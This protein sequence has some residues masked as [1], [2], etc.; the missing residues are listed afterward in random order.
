MHLAII[1][2]R[3]VPC[4]YGGFETFAQKLSISLVERGHKVSVYCSSLYSDSYQRY[5]K[6]VRRIVIPSIRKKSLDKPLYSFLSCLHASLSSYDAVLLLGVSGVV[7]SMLLRITGK[8]TV[9]NMDGLEWKRKK[10][11]PLGSSYLRFLEALSARFCNVIVADSRVIQAYFEKRYG[12]KPYYIPY[13]ADTKDAID[14]D[15]LKQYGLSSGEY[16]LQVCRLEPENNVH[17][18]I[19]EFEKTKTKK[20]LAI[21]GDAPYS[22]QYISSLKN[23]DDPRIKFLGA[24]YEEDYKVIQG[25]AYAYIHGHEVGGT[26]PALLEA[27]AAG[28]CAVVLDAPYNLEVIRGAGFSFSKDEGNLSEVIDYLDQNPQV[29]IEYKGRALQRIAQAY[30]WD[31]VINAY[32]GVF[33]EGLMNKSEGSTYRK[34]GVLPLQVGAV[35]IALAFCYWFTLA[36]LVQTWRENEDYSYGFL[37]PLISAYFLYRQRKSISRIPI[38]T[39]WP[40]FAGVLI[41]TLMVLFGEIGAQA[42]TA[43][44][45]LIVMVSALTLLLFGLEVFKKVAFPVW[46]LFFMLPLPNIIEH[47]LLLPLKLWSSKLSVHLIRFFGISVHQEGNVIDLGFSQLQVVD[48]CSGLRYI[49]PLIALGVVFSYL[50]QGER[51][52][53]A[54]IILITI[55]IAFFSNVFRIGTTGILTETVGTEVAEDFF[56][57]FSGLGIFLIGFGVLLVFNK[58]LNLAFKRPSEL[59]AKN[60][61]EKKGS[62]SYSGGNSVLSWTPLMMCVLILAVTGGLILRVAT[63]AAESGPAKISPEI[64]LNLGPWEGEISYVPA[65]IANVLQTDEAFEIGY[66]NS[67]THTDVRLYIGYYKAP[68]R[69]FGGVFAHTPDACLPGSGWRIMSK[70]KEVF[71]MGRPYGWAR[72]KKFVVRKTDINYLVYFWYQSETRIVTNSYLNQFALAWDALQSK[73]SPVLV[74]RIMTPVMRGESLVPARTDVQNFITQFQPMLKR[75]L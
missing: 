20:R 59:R 68:Y 75:G 36:L 6:G 5:F 50:F 67:K 29:V 41:A 55:P 17:I 46:F 8:F 60:L 13:G 71:D 47:R 32:E 65:N 43:R 57:S 56:H 1:G 3:G 4:N 42:Y 74:V 28:N 51:W 54:L 45:S 27:M 64:P 48:A 34:K 62:L 33:E 49:L 37:I 10:W 72:V 69:K 22:N 63:F 11:G 58:V 2:S 66:K 23:T 25:S 7:F 24:V 19:R 15:R 18:V 9:I 38:K 30:T 61:K 39:Y 73:H 52:K 44:L 53:Q 35:S 12:K 26:N 16:F 40:A 21:L 31:T 70:S 14:E